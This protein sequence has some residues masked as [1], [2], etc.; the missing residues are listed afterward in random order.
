MSDGT[1]MKVDT[2]EEALRLSAL[3][4]DS[5]SLDPENMSSLTKK[6]A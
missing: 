2:M 1:V 6:Q 3:K 4:R 5:S